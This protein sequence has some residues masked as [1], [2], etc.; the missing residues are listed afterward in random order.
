MDAERLTGKLIL[1]LRDSVLAAHCKGVVLGM[2]GGID[3]SA[4]A[5]ICQRAFPQ[6]TLGVIMPCHS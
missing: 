4:L 5:V 2:S 6:S 1:W 3:S